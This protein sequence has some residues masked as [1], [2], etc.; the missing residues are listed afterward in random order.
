VSSD[1]DRLQHGN[2]LLQLSVVF[3][4]VPGFDVNSVV[5]LPAEILLE[6]IDYNGAFKRP[7]QTSQIL[8]VVSLTG[9]VVLKMNRMLTVE[10]VCDYTLS[11]KAVQNFVGILIRVMRRISTYRLVS[12]CENHDFVVAAE[13]EQEMS[14]VR[15]DLIYNLRH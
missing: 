2:Q 14:G 5:L 7:A 9:E 3:V 1:S 15:S 6:I 13:L 4:A 11:V 10:T 8:N 12:S